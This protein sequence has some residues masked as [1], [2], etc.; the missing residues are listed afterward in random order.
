[1]RVLSSG[2]NVR[3]VWCTRTIDEVV[4]VDDERRGSGASA[5]QLEELP[6]VAEAALVRVKVVPACRVNCSHANII[7][8]FVVQY[9]TDQ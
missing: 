1:M 3:Q 9:Q 8:I 7:D 5:H 6:E 4:G 2:C